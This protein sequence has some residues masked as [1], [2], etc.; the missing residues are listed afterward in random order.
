M[1]VFSPVTVS[2]LALGSLFEYGW[3][4]AS[5]MQDQMRF[6]PQANNLWFLPNL[7]GTLRADLPEVIQKEIDL[8]GRQYLQKEGMN[9]GAG[10]RA[11]DASLKAI[12]DDLKRRYKAA[13][14]EWASIFGDL[15]RDV[16]PLGDGY[17][18]AIRWLM[19]PDGPYLGE[20]GRAQRLQQMGA[21]QTSRAGF[22]GELLVLGITSPPVAT[23]HLQA[24]A[25]A[26][27]SI[28]NTKAVLD[29]ARA[30]HDI[31][32][33]HLGDGIAAIL[34]AWKRGLDIVRDYL[35]AQMRAQFDAFDTNS[36]LF[37]QLKLDNLAD[38][39]A[40]KMEAEDLTRYDARLKEIL[41]SY[42][43]TV[44]QAAA[45][46][47]RTRDK[48]GMLVEEYSNRVSQASMQARAA[49]NS[50]G[51]SVSAGL[52]ERRQIDMEN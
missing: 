31:K 34:D 8:L 29:M 6:T 43:D 27:P 25:A 52:S 16:L 9:T 45:T 33:K 5:R 22:T 32:A 24:A 30:D 48:H 42:G 40:L 1:A 49:L 17:E 13:G 7:H 38:M 15:I 44:R 18:A 35:L 10:Q 39:T 21:I 4:T 47:Q 28:V 26:L 3:Q 51:L 2:A 20:L 12:L 19:N 46:N 14:D 50:N 37:T 36:P 41:A 23:P 11:M